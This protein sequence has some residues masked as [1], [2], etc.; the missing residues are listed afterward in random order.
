MMI[1]ADT[2]DAGPSQTAD[3]SS[4]LNTSNVC[5]AASSP[6]SCSMEVLRPSSAPP[7]GLNE[8]PLFKKR[9]GK[10]P[11]T[12]DSG[13]SEEALHVM[14]KMAEPVSIPDEDAA[15]KFGAFVASKLR[16]MDK[17]R[18]N[19]CESKIVAALYDRL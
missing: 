14:K 15:D 16:E 18:R 2:G 5:S 4:S 11:N 9:G 13:L 17:D 10:R 3:N 12:N 7:A 6:L 8:T 1:P 19:L